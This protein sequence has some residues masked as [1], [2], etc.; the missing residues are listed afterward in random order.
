MSKLK[1]I[2]D[3][4]PIFINPYTDFGFK[5]LFGEEANKDLLIDFLNQLMPNHHQVKDLYFQN[6]DNQSDT[7]YQRKAFFD[8]Q[9]VAAVTEEQFIVEMQKAKVVHFED[10]S[11]YYSTFPIKGQAKKGKD[12]DFELKPTY[13]I[14]ILDF[15]Y[16][17]H[18]QKR[19]VIRKVGLIDQNGELFSDNVHY[20]FIQM[21]L[22]NKKEEELVTKLDKW[23]YF[24]KNLENFDSIPEILNEPIFKKGFETAKIANMN[25]REYENYERNR[26]IY[27]ENESA[28]KNALVL[29][30][31]KGMEKG[32]EKGMDSKAY[33]MVKNCLLRG[34]SDEVTAE[35]AEV[36]HEFVTKVKTQLEKEGLLA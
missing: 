22:F 7:K 12:W 36:T 25:A 19:E 33:A 15:E 31:K 6:T 3:R 1:L 23:L 16:D 4:E 13:F 11:I 5:K 20:I 24:L 34:Y 26:M 18:Y 10:R 35:L 17:Q 27:W 9:C 21:P 28:M 29:G 30:E 14:A 2:L 32:M 8:I